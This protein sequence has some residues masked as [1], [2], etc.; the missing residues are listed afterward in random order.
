MKR[1][2]NYPQYPNTPGSG[3]APQPGGNSPYASG[4]PGQSQNYGTGQPY[5]SQPAGAA[6]PSHGSQP[7]GSPGQQPYGSQPAGGAGQQP[8]YGN[9]YANQG[10]GGGMPAGFGQPGPD[11]TVP[12][13]QPHYGASIKEATIRFFKKYVRFNGFASRSEF[14]WPVISIMVINAILW[15]PYM[16]GFF[17][18]TA[19]SAA[20]ASSYSSTG[21]S[22]GGGAAAIGG[23]LMLI[24]GGLL[25]LFLLAIILPSIG[26]TIRR[27]HDAGLSGWW[28]LLSLVPPGNIVVLV[29]CA[30]ESK[31]E[32]WQPEWYDQGA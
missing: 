5:G 23:I 6:H 27:L 13:D 29:F 21:A 32:K 10:M 19:G 26:V 14:W 11:G 8:A 17:M 3:N 24:F 30:L 9:S 22:G 1:V 7:V 28:I 4:A 12:L 20:A 31:P 2:S 15:V 25:L 18:W 16:I